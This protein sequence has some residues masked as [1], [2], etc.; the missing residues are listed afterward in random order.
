MEDVEELKNMITLLKNEIK[1]QY[2]LL[3]EKDKK[4]QQL[5]S[6]L[7]KYKNN[8][9]NNNNNNNI[10]NNSNINNDNN[11][12]NNNDIN[13]N[14][15]INNNI[16][17]KNIKEN[18]KII[19]EQKEPSKNLKTNENKNKIELNNFENSKNNEN[20]NEQLD[21][22]LAK[23]LEMGNSDSLINT[24]IYE[25]Q[26]KLYK[27]NLQEIEKNKKNSFFNKFINEIKNFNPYFNTNIPQKNNNKNN[28]F[29]IPKNVNLENLTYENILN[30]EDKIGYVSK[31]LNKKEIEKLGEEKYKSNIQ[32]ECVICMEI[33]KENEKIRK[34]K[35]LHIFHLNCID[36]W[37]EHNKNCPICK[38]DIIN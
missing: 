29:Q 15:N 14:I 24:M 23:Q 8:S 34:L 37:F 31:G 19:N 26:N 5:E 38:K 11:N 7:N 9:N 33:F 18:K 21:L 13:N 4:I 16:E 17:I 25:Q 6:E 22:L 3:K 1:I 27:K 32:K 12:N 20:I 35:C 10:N 2:E 28:N 30:L 36:E